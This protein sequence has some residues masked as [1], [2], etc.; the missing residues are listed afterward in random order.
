MVIR[1]AS[2]GAFLE[3]RNNISQFYIS[4]LSAI[5]DAKEVSKIISSGFDRTAVFKSL[6]ISR[7][8]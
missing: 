6:R 2:L 7:L 3:N 1:Q 5:P 8:I 4:T